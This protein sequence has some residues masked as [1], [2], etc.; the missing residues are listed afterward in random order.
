MSMDD[1]IKFFLRGGSTAS[2]PPRGDVDRV[3]LG[4]E[5]ALQARGERASSSTIRIA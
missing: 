2:S 1:E 5:D 3:A 4:L